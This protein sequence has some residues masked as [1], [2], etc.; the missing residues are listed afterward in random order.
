MPR[1]PPKKQ[2][3]EERPFPT[4]AYVILNL[5]FYCFLLM[6][7]WSASLF[8]RGEVTGLIPI[9]LA[10]GA[11]F[12]L[13]TLYDAFFDRILFHRYQ[14]A[15]AQSAE[16]ARRAAKTTDTAVPTPSTNAAAA[17][18]DPSPPPARTPKN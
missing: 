4:R 11:C 12:T 14:R 7:F 10:L 9:L 15:L 1:R 17:R 8:L 13:V 3:P 16:E 2:A 6:I 5:I 18:R